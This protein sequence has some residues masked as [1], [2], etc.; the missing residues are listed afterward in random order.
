M[1]LPESQA[2]LV[3]GAKGRLYNARPMSLGKRI[4]AA[5]KHIGLTQEDVA[6]AVGI[7]PPAV[8][9]W[10][11]DETVPDFDN[12]VRLPAILKVPAGW[13][14]QGGNTPPPDDELSALWE[15]L[16][17]AQRRHAMRFL[18]MLAEDTDQVA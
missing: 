7:S 14:L 8:S 12:L 5:R 10:E 2:T 1:A 16:T 3:S 17:P 4:R 18:K 13:L 9:S 11:R 15:R 6:H